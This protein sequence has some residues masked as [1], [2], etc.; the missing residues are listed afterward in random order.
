MKDWWQKLSID[1]PCALGDWLWALLIAEPAR[2]MRNI[3]R[4]RLLHF[5]GLLLLLLFFQQVV[6]MD[7][8]FL[9]YVD[10][11]LLMEVAAAIFVVAVRGQGKATLV[12]ARHHLVQAKTRIMRVWR[13][14]ARRIRHAARILLPPPD[15][16]GLAGALA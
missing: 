5:L 1:W 11:G 6:M 3:N 15:E 4:R 7:L 12:V 16:D 14:S 8:T 13:R 9:F 2:L 10:L